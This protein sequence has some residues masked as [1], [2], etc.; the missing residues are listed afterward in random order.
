MATASTSC[1][2][3]NRKWGCQPRENVL[4]STAYIRVQHGGT[5][6]RRMEKPHDEI[7]WNVGRGAVRSNIRGGPSPLVQVTIEPSPLSERFHAADGPVGNS[8]RD[9]VI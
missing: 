9:L 4:S 3:D 6:D 7:I 8:M 5:R 1:S 2:G